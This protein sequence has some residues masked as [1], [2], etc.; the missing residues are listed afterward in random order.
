VKSK[1][2]AEAKERKREAGKHYGER[3]PKEQE[4][5][6]LIDEPLED[7]H[8]REATHHLARVFSTNRQ[9]VCDAKL[10]VERAVRVKEGLGKPSGRESRMRRYAVVVSQKKSWF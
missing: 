8:V 6:Q 1:L 5:S 3:H 7:K 4:V 2:E 10:L 9:Y